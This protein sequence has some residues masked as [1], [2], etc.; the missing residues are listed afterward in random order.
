[1]NGHLLL[2][3]FALWHVA[4]SQS[5]ITETVNGVAFKMIKV[6]GGTFEMGYKEGR[7]GE[8]EYMDHAKPSHAVTLTDYYIG[9]TEVTQALWTAVMGNNPSDFKDCD[10]C[11]V[12]TVSWQDIVNDFLPKLNQL[13]GKKYT[14]PTEAQW[15]YAARGGKYSKEYL[16][17][18]SSNIGD[19][20]WYAE[21]SQ[22]RT[23]PVKTRSPNEL[24]LYDM[25]GNVFE[26]CQDG[27]DEAFYGSADATRTNPF[28]ST[29]VSYRVLCGGS[30]LNSSTDCR[31][32]NRNGR[33][34]PGFRN[35]FNG[36]RL[37]LQE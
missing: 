7:D 25:S 24:G 23:H 8:N 19:V 26:W 18:G 6:E 4:H 30:W 21:N 11:P 17:A 16:Y 10:E 32:A 34:N 13:T 20:A 33:S 5:D 35:Y 36:F 1:M 29:K 9:E 31:V 3:S 28:Q 22:D 12:E 14:L 15:E 27:Y 2:L 37:S